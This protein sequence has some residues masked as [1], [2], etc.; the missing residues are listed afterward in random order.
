MQVKFGKDHDGFLGSPLIGGI[1]EVLKSPGGEVG[2]GKTSERITVKIDKKKKSKSVQRRSGE[3][4]GKSCNCF[5][6]NPVRCRR[7]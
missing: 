5:S 1:T 3:N 2:A 4:H 6:E 7:N